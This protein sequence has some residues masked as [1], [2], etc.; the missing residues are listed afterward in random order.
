[1][2]QFSKRENLGNFFTYVNQLTSKSVKG[3]RG[4]FD[5]VGMSHIIVCIHK[6]DTPIAEEKRELLE[7]QIGG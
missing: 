4:Y 5:A 6:V 1:M 3:G 2:L 7:P